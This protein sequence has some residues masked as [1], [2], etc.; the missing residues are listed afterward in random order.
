MLFHPAD[1]AQQLENVADAHFSPWWPFLTST[2][3]L[4][5]TAVEEANSQ[6]IYAI[7]NE[8]TNTTYF[9]LMQINMQGKCKFWA[10]QPEKKCNKTLPPVDGDSEDV[11]GG[12]GGLPKKKK[13]CDLDLGGNKAKVPPVSRPPPGL[14]GGFQPS[15]APVAKTITPEEQ[16]ML[17][18]QREYNDPTLA[19]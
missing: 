15:A 4:L 16:N 3:P 19:E 6:Q 18:T 11:Q 9:R 8:L 14:L 1:A 17:N 10:D 2:S 13:A 12:G 5:V 7:L